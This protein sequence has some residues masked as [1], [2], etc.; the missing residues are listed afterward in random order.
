MH[1][2]QANWAILVKIPGAF[3]T[4]HNKNMSGPC[5]RWNIHS[6]WMMFKQSDGI[7]ILVLAAKCLQFWLNSRELFFQEL[8]TCCQPIKQWEQTRS[9]KTRP[10]YS[11]RKGGNSQISRENTIN[12]TARVAIT[13]VKHFLICLLIGL[14]WATGRYKNNVVSVLVITMLQL[15]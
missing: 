3:Q 4:D 13:Q 8:L 15:K 1:V 12:V 9:L 11:Y 5:S 2:A 10:V 6:L 14:F 7:T